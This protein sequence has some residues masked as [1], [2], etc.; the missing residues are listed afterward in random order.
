M[1]CDSRR[2]GSAIKRKREQGQGYGNRRQAAKDR[3]N[4]LIANGHGRTLPFT[5]I[6]YYGCVHTCIHPSRNN[7]CVLSLTS[8]R[9][10]SSSVAPFF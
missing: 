9:V 10:L 5:K 8:H 4:E 7:Y 3:G 1:G 6:G 2:G